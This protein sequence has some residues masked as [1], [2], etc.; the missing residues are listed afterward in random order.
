MR[1]T[2]TISDGERPGSYHPRHYRIPPLHL[3][4]SVYTRVLC[5]KQLGFPIGKRKEPLHN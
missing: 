5:Q 4:R 2:I 3:N 1:M